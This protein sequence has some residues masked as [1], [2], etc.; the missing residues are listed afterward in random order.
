MPLPEQEIVPLDSIAPG[1]AGLR[2][3]FVNLYALTGEDGRWVLVDA[4]L[5]LSASKIRNW[6]DGQFGAGAR[7]EAILLTH[8]HFDHVGVLEDLANGWNVPVY[9]HPNE[10][11]YLNGQVKY[12]P[13]DP[14]VGGGLM[15]VMSPL[16]PRTSADVRNRARELPADGSVPFLPEWR[17]THTPG[18]APGHVSLFRERDRVLLPADAFCT[19]NQNSFLSVAKQ[20]PELSGPPAYYTPDWDSARDSVE[21][22]AALRPLTIAPGHGLPI[23]GPAVA[24]QLATL[25]RE[26]DR[27]ARPEH[28]KYARPANTGA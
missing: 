25:A 9:A 11:P 23:S 27:I 5:P 21:R 12:P 24:E 2:V 10:I 1:V 18:H 19:T 13:P 8:G 14:T 4:G 20:A 16:Y 15:A 26:F 7:P 22:L 28:G 3:I 17:W 6:L